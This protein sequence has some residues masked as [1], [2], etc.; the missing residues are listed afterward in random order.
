MPTYSFFNELRGVEYEE[1]MKNSEYDALLKDN[2]HIKRVWDYAPAI[3]GDHI[4]GVG[5]KT[6]SGFHENMQRIAEGHPNSPL[7][8]RYGGNKTHA[9]I[10]S[11]TVAKKHGLINK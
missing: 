9:R 8:D 6:D 5:P 10:K 3:V 11:E 2:P 4:A 7:A 1:F